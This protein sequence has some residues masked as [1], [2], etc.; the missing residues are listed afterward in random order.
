[1]VFGNPNKLNSA[2]AIMVSKGGESDFPKIR[3]KGEEYYIIDPKTP[4][5]VGEFK[6][7]DMF[8]D[9]GGSNNFLA[10]NFR[11]QQK[12][13]DKIKQW[14][15]ESGVTIRYSDFPVK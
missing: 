5:I 13:L 11:L 15:R 10:S 6:Y 2:I 8:D 1:M 9:P 14:V 3:I 12:D 7:G 4:A